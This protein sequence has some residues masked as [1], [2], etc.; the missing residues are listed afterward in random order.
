MQ[1]RLTRAA[2]LALC[3]LVIAAASVVAS[4][5]T[6]ERTRLNEA[7][8]VLAAFRSDTQTGIPENLWNRAQCV[9]VIP[10]LKKAAFIFG[11]EFGRGVMSCRTGDA[12]SAPVFMQ[13]A[14]GSWGFQAG[15]E[16]IDLVLVVMNRQ[17]AE[18]LLSNTVSLG[19][20]ASVAAGPVGRAG[21]AST[22]AAL[23]A[24]ILT[25]SRAKD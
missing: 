18:K 3:M 13:L 2:V 9:I 22:D 6:A 14:K 1:L 10:G 25:Y 5:S 12:W 15:A 4:V 17:G 8:S 11:G 20:D 23:T 24:E 21:S 19:V 7:A 16:A